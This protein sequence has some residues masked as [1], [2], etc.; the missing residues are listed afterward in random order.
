M[1]NPQT[2]N[3]SESA[4]DAQFEIATLVQR[5]RAAQQAIAHYTQAQ[6]DALVLA[7]GWSVVKNKEALARAAVDEGRSEERR[8]GKECA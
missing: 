1:S 7:V 3:A 5:A 4:A 6:V 8:V 2:P